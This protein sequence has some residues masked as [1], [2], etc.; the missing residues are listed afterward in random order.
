MAS[1]PQVRWDPNQ[2]GR[3]GDERGRPFDELV[4]RAALA[5]AGRAPA[6]VVDL[7]CGP[8]DLTRRLADRWPDAVILGV[9]SSP[10]MIASARE[11]A[12]EGRLSFELADV[13]TW[14]PPQPCD[15]IV[16]N[17]VLHWIPGHVDL[18]PDL[19]EQLS[20]GGVLAFQVPDNFEE[21]SHTLL[22]DL[23]L[24]P[25][26]NEQ[27]GADADRGAGVERPERYLRAVVDAG[28]EPDV[29]QTEYLH[30]LPGDD[31]VLEW[32]KGTALRPVL[33][34]LSGTDRDE[35]LASYAESLRAAYPKQDFGTV[36][37]FRRT[38]V[39][40]RDRRAG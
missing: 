19:A 18:V 36:F 1:T 29:W 3:Y 12:I 6:S 2:Y 34:R 9:D 27:L 26:W 14:R 11:H 10:E 8:G 38:F 5:L 28:L 4:S 39:I 22:R 15:F 40:G 21:P 23:R 25:R 20:T 33:S 7:G 24:S 17:A 31:A 37:P 13:S 16:G 32:V 30:I 35:F